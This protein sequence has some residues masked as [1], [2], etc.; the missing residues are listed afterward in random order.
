M[1]HIIAAALMF[2]VG[3][4]LAAGNGRESW[5]DL[6][7]SSVNRLPAHASASPLPAPVGAYKL[8]LIIEGLR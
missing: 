6:T 1:K 5:R 3:F 4:S 8:F 2:G 7:V